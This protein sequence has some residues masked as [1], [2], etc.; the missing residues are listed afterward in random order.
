[1]IAWGNLASLWWLGPVLGLT[2]L[3]VGLNL[4]FKLWVNRVLAG[5]LVN[6]FLNHKYCLKGLLLVLA[7]LLL[8]LAIL[9]PR[10]GQSNLPMK[11]TGRDLLIALD[12]S[13]SMLAQDLGVSRLEFAKNK[14]NRL[15][16][17]LSQDRVGLILFSGEAILFCPLTSDLEAMRAFLLDVSVETVS[18]GT[19]DLAKPI[20]LGLQLLADS[21]GN[22]SQLLA[23]FTDGEDFSERL[24][25]AAEQ[26]KKAGLCLF[27]IGVATEQGSPIPKINLDGSQDGY[28]KDPQG[29]VVLS[30]LNPGLLTDLAAK[31]GG[32]YL[33]VSTSDDAD[34]QALQKFLAR[35]EKGQFAASLKEQLNEKYYY[36]AGLALL[37]LSL[38]WLI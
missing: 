25:V 29:Q 4:K 15:L 2:L 28:L 33:P 5:R 21:G 7:T 30:K 27:A 31:S 20:E 35:F 36:F 18:S 38:E 14:I 10:W 11:C 1:M 34:L 3:L 17:L 22:R 16:E 8:G 13:K 26:A 6:Q 9:A 12:V 32:M 24:T 19:T 23:I 37:S